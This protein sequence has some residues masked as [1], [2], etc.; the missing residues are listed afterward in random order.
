MGLR[1]RVWGVG[2]GVWGLGFLRGALK[3]PFKMA[4]SKLFGRTGS[5]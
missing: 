2:I 5:G 3:D 4:D 1:F